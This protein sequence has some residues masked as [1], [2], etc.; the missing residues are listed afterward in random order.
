MAKY[1]IAG[2]DVHEESVLV[3]WAVDNGE[4]HR[5][6]F[7]ASGNGRKAM[8][9]FLKAEAQEAGAD[10]IA[11]AYEACCFGFG[12]YDDLTEAGIKCHVLAPSRIARSPKHIRAKTDEKDAAKILE[13]LRSHLLAAGEMYDVWVPDQETRQDRM[14]VRRRLEVGEKR[15]RVRTQIKMLLK[16]ADIARPQSLGEGWTRRYVSWLRGLCEA[17]GRL[18]MGE[19]ISLDSLIREM[20]WLDSEVAKLDQD[21]AALSGGARYAA[22]VREMMKL[23]GVGL[24]TGMV[25]LAEMGDL[26]RF[27][28]RRTV[29]AY[30]GLVPSSDESGEKSD[31][32]GHLTKQGS[33]R[34]RKVLCQA[35][36]SRSR[37]EP[38]E[39]AAHARIMRRNPKKGKIA[40]VALM[41]RLAVRMWHDGLKAQREAGCYARQ[42]Q[43][44]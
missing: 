43:P 7:D 40:L 27:P 37:S 20:E 39:K 5:R 6:S 36:W 23:R 32:K 10:R 28:N 38:D 9:K 33:R 4:A 26:S 21:L 25:Y 13:I 14:V 24:L 8:I 42:M 1:I 2:G 19:A 15:S 17:G 30:L 22:P 3:K 11:F 29:A 35:A 12:L 44:A 41:R 31:R 16:G 18:G 34:I